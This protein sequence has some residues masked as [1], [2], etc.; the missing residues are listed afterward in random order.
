MTAYS[1]RRVD[2]SDPDKVLK[3]LNGKPYTAGDLLEDLRLIFKVT[4]NAKCTYTQLGLLIPEAEPL[5]R[6]LANI[7]PNKIHAQAVDLRTRLIPFVKALV[8]D[9]TAVRAAQ[10]DTIK[11]S[12]PGSECPSF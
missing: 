3:E 4:N 1:V 8:A 12:D 10:R 6:F 11:A 9:Q 5:W 2:V 7:F